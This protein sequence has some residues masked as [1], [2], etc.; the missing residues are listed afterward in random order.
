MKNIFRLSIYSACVLSLVHIDAY[1]TASS[2]TFFTSVPLFQIGQPTREMFFSNARM[3]AKEDGW[4]GAW[5][6]VGYGGQ[7]INGNSISSYFMP[8]RGGTPCKNYL[9]VVEYKEGVNVADGQPTKD[10]EARNFNISTA[11]TTSTFHSLI[12]FEP[13]QT[14]AGVGF[15]F[16]QNLWRDRLGIPTFW[17]ELSFPVQYVKNEMNLQ[18]SIISD[19]GGSDGQPGLDGQ[20]HVSSMTEAFAQT[21]WQFGK[22]NNCCPQERWGVADVEFRIG[23]NSLRGDC[24][25]INAYVG[26]VAPTG[27]QIDRKTAGYLFPAI[28]GNN[29][30]FG[31]L[32]GSHFGYDLHSRNDHMLRMEL[33]MSNRML[34]TNHQ[35]RSFDLVE[36]GDWSRFLEVYADLAQATEASAAP[37]PLQVNLGTSGINVFTRQVR[38][39][40]RFS[41]NINL[42]LNYAYKKA[43]FELGY[44]LYIR[45]SEKVEFPRQ[46][47][48]TW[49][50]TIAVKDIN[51]LGNVNIAR[52]IKNNFPNSD[53]SFADYAQYVIQPSNLNLDS[54]AHGA[55]MT[56]TI[57]GGIAYNFTCCHVP[58]FIGVG[59]MYEFS[60]MNTAFNRWNALGKIGFSY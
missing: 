19:G 35:W 34:F 57:Y 10:V 38:V 17:A 12:S 36:E 27:T 32:F 59:G 39:D 16:K 26:F 31:V 37:S 23:Y 58:F 15:V 30:H 46:S 1:Q 53:I 3:E 52:T 40:P 9:S 25:D 11:S 28:I 60:G 5:E 42:A 22:I 20:T 33:D 8:N 51:G 41:S 14:T 4:G 21:S 49:P 7:S 24:C 48:S 56:N 47:C 29:H 44:N 18:E 2:K 54:A 6:V 43:D 50:L 55:V 45:Q 13:K